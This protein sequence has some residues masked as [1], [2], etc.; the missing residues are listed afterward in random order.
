MKDEDTDQV[1][2]RGPSYDPI[3]VYDGFDAQKN[4]HRN[5]WHHFTLSRRTHQAVILI[6]KYIITKARI[7]MRKT[8]YDKNALDKRILNALTSFFKITFQHPGNLL[9]AEFT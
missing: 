5:I 9:P 7:P 1:N 6:K 3:H 2:E 8:D 4:A